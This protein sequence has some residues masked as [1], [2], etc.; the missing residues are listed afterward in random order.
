[1]EKGIIIEYLNVGESNPWNING[2]VY[3][4]LN[5]SKDE[6]SD[7]IKQEKSSYSFER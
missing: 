4:D 3:C 6:Y 7:W 5:L 1:M 2:Y